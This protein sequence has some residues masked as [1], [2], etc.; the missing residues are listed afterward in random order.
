MSDMTV[1]LV[2]NTS[3]EITFPQTDVITVTDIC[4]PVLLIYCGFVVFT[5]QYVFGAAKKTN[6][7]ISWTVAHGA[8][9]L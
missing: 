5:V 9:M 1:C 3:T 8:F 6:D 4:V 2:Q 7:Y